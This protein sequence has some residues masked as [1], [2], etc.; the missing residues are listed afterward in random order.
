[1]WRYFAAVLVHASCAAAQAAESTPYVT[2]ATQ[3]DFIGSA[4]PFIDGICCT[5]SAETCASGLY[6][7]TC[8]SSACARAVEMVADGCTSWLAEPK[9]T[10]I[11]VTYNSKRT[12]ICVTYNSAGRHRQAQQ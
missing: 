11:C 7:S 2:C 10:V 5:Q 4:N 6:P 1:M 12:V 3:I 9:R 8:T